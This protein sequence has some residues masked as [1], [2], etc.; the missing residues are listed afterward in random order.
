MCQKLLPVAVVGCG[1]GRSH[2]AQGYHRHSDKFR[3]QALC[4]ID[5]ARL[6]VVADEFSIPRRTTSFDDVLRMDD[7]DIVDICTPAA[8][9]F[10][11]ILA[12]L[13][14]GK[15][16]V[17]EKPLVLSLAEIDQVIAAENS[18]AGRVMP[19]FQYRFGNGVQKAKRLID[20][21]IAGKPYLATVETAWKRTPKYY[22][23]PWRGRWETERGGV[24]LMH[25]IH[26]HDLMT[27][28]M[29][30]I[31][32]VF[33]RTATRVNS[34]EVEDCAVASLVMRSGAL[35]SLAATLGSHR[36]I[37]RLRLSFEH[38]M[39]ESGEAAYAPGDDPWDI[40]PASPQAE[41]RIAEAL[42]GYRSMPSRYEGQLGAYHAAL[43]SGGAL[44]V[45]LADARTSLE[46][47]TALYHSAATG[48][49]VTLPI[50]ADHPSYTGW[51]SDLV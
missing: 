4:D 11:Q 12:A 49:A 23:T 50:A 18:A 15:E 33:A 42:V 25:A 22:E 32:S 51:A 34:I 13:A 40:V 30:P 1:V 48:A 29:G 3:V 37:S 47:A 19:I 21:G 35:A 2:I 6:A 9:H 26:S 20:L 24:L 16:V 46:L 38:L 39:F 5:A 31:A 27:W 43:T 8:F 41:R 7:I 17:C 28:L 45:T 10:G 14:A 44:P 36:E